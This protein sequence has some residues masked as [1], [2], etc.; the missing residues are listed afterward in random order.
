MSKPA[1][2]CKTD[3]PYLVQD[4]GEFANSKGAGIACK[5]V[6][7]LC[8]CGGSATKPFCD[9]THRKNGFSGAKSSQ[10][11][12]KR[13][14]YRGK[15]ITIFDDRAICAHS[16]RCSDNLASVFKYGSE[17]WIDPDGAGVG[18]I[19]D[20][21]HQCPSGALSYA[22]D[23]LEAPAQQRAPG[24]TVTKDGP[25][26]VVGSIPLTG[27]GSDAIAARECYTLCRC[28]ASKNKPFCDGSHWAVQFS[29]PTT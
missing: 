9:G 16:A 27:Q 22:V 20:A 7:V 29:D 28:G 26:A 25:Y 17:P 8:R 1:I 18:A 2:G 14:T 3:G 5:P 24:I 19:I 11:A 6:M 4:L 13:D 15:K 12:A 23:D 10:P 21:V